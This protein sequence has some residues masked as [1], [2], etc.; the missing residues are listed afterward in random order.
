MP[1]PAPPIEAVAAEHLGEL[2]LDRLAVAADRDP[3]DRVRLAVAVVRPADDVLECRLANGLRATRDRVHGVAPVLAGEWRAIAPLQVVAQRVRERQAILLL[4]DLL[5]EARLRLT[6][7]VVRPREAEVEP[8]PHEAGLRVRRDDR[9]HGLR[10]AG[11]SCDDAPTGDGLVRRRRT[12]CRAGAGRRR[13]SAG[14]RGRHEHGYA[15]D[16][17]KSPHASLCLPAPPRSV[18]RDTSGIRR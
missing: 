1:P 2:D 7:L 6:R 18:S 4:L 16:R 17:D 3:G 14:A 11:R 13:L 8:L 12:G 15:E 5:S 10:I 9:L